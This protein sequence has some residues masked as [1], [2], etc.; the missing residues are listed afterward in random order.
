MSKF[1]RSYFD[2]FYRYVQINN[3]TQRYSNISIET[4]TTSCILDLIQLYLF[5]LVIELRLPMQNQASLRKS[6]TH[7]LD[8]M[9]H[10]LIVN[11][12]YLSVWSQI[13]NV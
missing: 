6:V 10:Y 9:K 13:T 4:A 1:E 12:D 11:K 8:V 7:I 3:Q 2:L 5:V